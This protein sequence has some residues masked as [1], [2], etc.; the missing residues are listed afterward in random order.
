MS[1]DLSRQ[2]YTSQFGPTTGDR[3]HLADTGLIAEIENDSSVYGDEMRYGAGRTVR[4]AIGMKPDATGEEGALDW[5]I[6]NAVVI[7]PILGIVKG[8]IGVKDGRIAGVGNAGNPDTMSGVDDDLVVSANTDIYPGKGFIATPGAVAI[9]VHWNNPGLVPTALSTGVTTMLGGGYGGMS[10]TCTPGRRNIEYFIKAAERWPVNVGF[11]GKG[12]SSRA[13]VL[14][15]QIEWGACG[16]KVH[17]DWGA[18]P[19]IIDACL[20]VTEE[21]DVQ[22]CLHTD[23]LNEFGFAEDT[24]EAIDGRTIHMFHV[25]GAG[26]GH[27]PDLLKLVGEQNML[28][29][30]TGP[31]MPYTDNAIDEMQDMII[32]AHNLDPSTPEDVAVASSRVRG[33]TMAAEDV[34]HDQG[35]I[36]M[37]TTDALA[38][39]RMGE[40]VCKTWQTAGKMKAQFGPLPSDE[41]SDNDNVRIKRY[42]AKYTI[43]PAITA[44][45]D[46]HVGSLERGKIADIALWEPSFFGRKPKH[47]MKGGFPVRSNTGKA[48]ASVPTVQPMKL[49]DRSG[50]VGNAPSTLSVLFTSH[51]AVENDIAT[52]YGLDTPVIPVQGTNNLN[53]EHM[54]YNDYCPD[55]ITVNPE[56]FEV[57]I[58]GEQ[59]TCEPVDE[60]PLS[61]RYML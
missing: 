27:A 38:M 11:Y 58:D 28:P 41:E 59:I 7:D 33:E 30:S 17:E 45:I 49:R 34:L 24:F 18:T 32:G 47:I 57:R 19:E 42:I 26:G 40:L 3:I 12:T 51:A 9:H 8:D 61:Q 10:T 21:M 50:A 37:M 14:R 60:L 39:G 25:E 46:D 16:M 6:T 13:P 43:N 36:P 56:T 2:E 35:A 29:S 22:I 23:T 52:R 15:E 20:N 53:R 55:N 48:N 44:G 4:D 5:V 54:V 31:T 1:R